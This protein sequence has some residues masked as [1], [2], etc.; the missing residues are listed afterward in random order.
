MMAMA[1]SRMSA[2]GAI[3]LQ[4]SDCTLHPA[5]AARRPMRHTRWAHKMLDRVLM[6]IMRA[7]V[8]ASDFLRSSELFVLTLKLD[9]FCWG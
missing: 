7:C 2:S 1:F 9:L 8:A 6:Y 4:C 3:T 5:D